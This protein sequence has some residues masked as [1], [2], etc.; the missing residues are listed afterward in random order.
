MDAASMVNVL[1]LVVGLGALL[2]HELLAEHLAAEIPLGRL[3]V[4]QR[5]ARIAWAGIVTVA[6]LALA[7]TGLLRLVV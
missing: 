4:V 2:H 5:E 1:L 3:R 6:G 7:M